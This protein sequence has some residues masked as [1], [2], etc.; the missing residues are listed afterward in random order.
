M[1][2]AINWNES[3]HKSFEEV[4]QLQAMLYVLHTSS[5]AYEGQPSFLQPELQSYV[6]TSSCYPTP[7][8]APKAGTALANPTLLLPPGSEWALHHSTAPFTQ[9][10][11]LQPQQ[12]QQAGAGRGALTRA[13]QA[14]LSATL[15]RLRARLAAGLELRLE[16]WPG[17]GLGL[18]AG[19]GAG[20]GLPSPRRFDVIN[21]SNVA[22]H[23]G[24]PGVLVAAA[25]RLREGGVLHTESILWSTLSPGSFAGYLRKVLGMP[26]ETAPTLLALRLLTDLG[27]G[28]PAPPDQAMQIGAWTLNSMQLVWARTEP[29][30]APLPQL[31]PLGPAGAAGRLRRGQ[32]GL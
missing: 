8:S 26:L 15:R 22:D 14:Q 29:S 25:P 23:S 31:A 17:K 4:V 30:A 28:R 5:M 10:S 24:L 6:H 1:T 18:C 9:F 21:T 12:L 13:C 20:G 19:S 3:T 11:P 2:D 16:L 27:A 7:G 32:R